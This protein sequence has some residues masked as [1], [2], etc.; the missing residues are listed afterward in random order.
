MDLTS[1]V[2]KKKAKDDDAVNGSGNTKRKA[3]E[4]STELETK[5]TKVEEEEQTAEADK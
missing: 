3:D 4:E 1:L 2:R 5:R